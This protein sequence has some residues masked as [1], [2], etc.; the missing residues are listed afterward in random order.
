MGDSDGVQIARQLQKGSRLPEKLKGIMSGQGYHFVG[1]HSAIKTCSY[2]ASSMRLEGATCYKSRFYGIKSWRCMQSTPAI[3]CN[4]SCSFC[5]RII[6]E[7]IGINW[8]ELNAM[9]DWDDPDTIV[10]GLI[11][12]QRRLVS[13]FKENPKTDLRRWREA[14]DP[15]H[16]ALSLTGEPMF[17]PMMSKLL[18]AFHR[19]KIS[20]FL[21]TNGTMIGALQKLSVMPTQLYVS[22]QAPNE[23][24]YADTA[25]AKTLSA[26]QS[27]QKF[28]DVFSVLPTRRV[29]RLTLVKGVNMVDA[30]GY[31]KLIMCGRPNY[32]EVKG[33]SFVGGA[34]GEE[35]HLSYTQMPKKEEVI[36]FAQEIARECGYLVTDYHEHSKVVLLCADE[37]SAN[38]RIIDFQK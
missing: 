16:V 33:F 29:F 35:R 4:L 27:F 30:K 31:A 12:E 32:V 13:G 9:G 11:A 26:W 22:I 6:P 7:E 5:W 25:R 18:E 36:A 19:R 38:S 23:Q 20:T 2:T 10:D 21:V 14:N 17:Y 37:Q 15:A 24:I 34:R 8:N 28:L 1:R 3:G